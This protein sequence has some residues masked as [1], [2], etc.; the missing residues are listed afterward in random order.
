VLLRWKEYLN[1]IGMK[2]RNVQ[3]LNQVDLREDG[4][5]ISVKKGG[6]RRINCGQAAEKRGLVNA[7]EEV[8]Y[9]AWTSETLTKNWTKEEL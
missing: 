8:I 3:P 9:L 4:V 6:R 7:L 1:N 2:K 5:E